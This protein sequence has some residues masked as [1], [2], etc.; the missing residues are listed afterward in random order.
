MS[1]IEELEISG[2]R[3]FD[4]NTREN[5][6]FFKPLTVI[7]G[8]NGAG[9]T[10]II[11]SLLN[12]TAG[13]FPPGCG[14]ER[15]SFVY[16]P[17]VIGDSTVKAQVRLKFTA[18]DG[19][20]CRVVRSYE[21][22]NASRKSDKPKF[23]SL[24]TV[25]TQKDGKSGVFA[26]AN[27]GS[28][29]ADMRMRELLGVSSAVLEHVIFCHQEDCNWPLGSASDV[30]PIFDAIFAATRYVAA[31]ENLKDN[32]KRMAKELKEYERTLVELRQ[33][34]DQASELR[35]TIKR[36]E[37]GVRIIEMRNK[38]MEPQVQDLRSATAA[39]DAMKSSADRLTV[40]AA[41]VEGRIHE[42]VLQSKRSNPGAP[43]KQNLS[44]LLEMRQNFHAHMDR[45]DVEV[46][47]MEATISVMDASRRQQ[48]TQQHEWRSK[49]S[50]LERDAREHKDICSQIRGFTNTLSEEFVIGEDQLDETALKRLAVVVKDN[51]AASTQ[52]LEK[53][54][55]VNSSKEE[56]LENE[57][58][59]LLRNLDADAKEREMK[60]K[61][62]HSLQHRIVEAEEQLRTR[63]LADPDSMEKECVALQA[64]LDAAV[65][66]RQQGSEYALESSLTNQLDTGNREIASL[67]LQIGERKRSCAQ[68]AKIPFLRER[69]SQ[70]ESWASDQVQMIL[71]E[72][73]KLG[74]V[75]ETPTVS[76][77]CLAVERL[78][79]QKVE[80][81]RTVE[82]EVLQLEHDISAL[83]KNE[84][85]QQDSLSGKHVELQRLKAQFSAAAGPET[86]IDEYESE[87]ASADEK[88]LKCCRHLSS[89]ES[90][91]RCYEGFVTTAKN[92]RQCVVCKRGLNDS[93]LGDFIKLNEDR[94]K[95]TP[96][97]I[98]RSR[99][100]LK[101]AQERVQK[102]KNV[103]TIA[104]EIN[105]IQLAAAEES[106]ALRRTQSDLATKRALLGD[107]T[108]KRHNV[109]S[110]VAI[111]QGL[112]ELSNRINAAVI[113]TARLKTE[114]AAAEIA[115]KSESSLSLEELEG[116]YD[117]LMET[118]Q[119]LSNQLQELQRRRA[120]GGDEF[121][122]QLELTKRR[123]DLLEARA[124][125]KQID[126]Q[127][128]LVA[129]LSQ[130]VEDHRNRLREIAIR[131][132]ELQAKVD[133]SRSSLQQ[134]KATWQSVFQGLT[135]TRNRFEQQATELDRLIPVALRYYHKKTGDALARAKEAQK[136]AESSSAQV[137]SDMAALRA[138]IA[139]NQAV[140]SDQHRQFAN[141]NNHIQYLELQKSLEDDRKHLVAITDELAKLKQDPLRGLTHLIG[142]LS[143]SES[144]QSIRDTLQEK[145][146]ELE[147]VRAQSEGNAEA[148]RA[149]IAEM[150]HKLGGERF[151]TIDD[152]YSSIFIK[153]QTLELAIG[154][155]DKYYK[156]LDKAVQSYHQ[157]K[158][159]QVNAIISELWRSIYRGSDIDTIELKSEV[160]GV[161]ATASG[162][163]KRNYNYRVVMKRG[164]NEIDM[165]AK[166]SA[167]QK[168]LACVVIRV[169]LSEAFST[170]C[171]VLA[172]D[173]PTTNL[174][175]DNARSLAEALRDLIAA[176]R[177]SKGFQLVVITH[178]EQFVRALGSQSS[179]ERFY[180]VHKDREGAF[181][182]IEERSFEQL[183]A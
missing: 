38:G 99:R 143:G 140:I 132:A 108:N 53:E 75:V 60:E 164:N 114:L 109:E 118:Q 106:T 83:L 43:T 158:I 105:R 5:V 26:H 25:I 55:A 9:K 126:A 170:D 135:E 58:N 125:Q 121:A 151:H 148:I 112:F 70:Q 78:R 153:L 63:P 30:K 6:T 130:E 45:L 77:V 66:I 8:N 180:F 177:N 20:L 127:R 97:Q 79:D 145:I 176:R 40:E 149:E 22:S 47:K 67:R 139:K 134:L 123:S 137:S 103:S 160:E 18:R 4:P 62:V 2:V 115:D 162:T 19:N 93:A 89:I 96:E 90:M 136:A 21:V 81:Q 179:V 57:I 86:K 100:D 88:H 128:S 104:K 29:E 167:G 154:D 165:R 41:Q 117:K 54:I 44:E 87:L 69:I 116:M 146:N 181:S 163:S 173:E 120:G 74:R 14:T 50:E 171:G 101:I 16:D 72:L 48:E 144:V 76:N 12:A 107:A 156:A 33:H 168:V 1:S 59:S 138:E 131:R 169:A 36:R 142:H 172:L 102:L 174:D 3:S 94:Q 7:L 113:E 31:L 15:S 84:C 23:C 56:A 64:R 110:Q 95:T 159:V 11:E 91:A 152:R 13:K 10:T 34:K 65:A 27:F 175:E 46:K 155:I 71:P 157:D 51:H 141:L 133:A 73:G 61:Q 178:D 182:K 39:L 161:A 17:K 124:A 150:Q 119:S 166:C 183:F 147:R 52:N 98:D 80:A 129:S 35:E 85:L 49:V 32:H 68:E 122:I 111:V 82:R 92:E 24:D 42:K 37:E 28:S